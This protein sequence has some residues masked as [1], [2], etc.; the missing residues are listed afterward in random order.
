MI[1]TKTRGLTCYDEGKATMNLI[2]CEMEARLERTGEIFTISF[3]P[4]GSTTCYFAELPKEF[5]E[6]IRKHE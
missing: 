3:M 5:I 4:V 1:V 6:E 2:P